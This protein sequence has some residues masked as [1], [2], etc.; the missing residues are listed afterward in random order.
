MKMAIVTTF[1]LFDFLNANEGDLSITATDKDGN[2]QT[3]TSTENTERYYLHKYGAR[4]YS[5]LTGMIPA[6]ASDALSNFVQDFHAWVSNRQHNIDLQYQALYNYDYSPIDNYDRYELETIGDR[7]TTT[8]GKRDS[9]SGSDTFTHGHIVANTGTTTNANSGTDTTTKTGNIV[10]ETEKAGFNSPNSYT[11]DTK[12]T[13]T[14]NS[15]RDATAYGKTETQTDNTTQTNSGTD[16]TTYG[17]TNTLSGSDSTSKDITRNLH[18]HGNIGVT[19][20][21]AMISE[22]IDARNMSLAEM[23]LDNFINDYTFYS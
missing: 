2:T 18:T 23:L 4:K 1:E 6:D 20:S 14:Y 13:E 7:G 22:L 17:E 12:N 16:T 9:K 3:I 19:T 15:V 8:Y 5:V 10:D 21:T 11:N